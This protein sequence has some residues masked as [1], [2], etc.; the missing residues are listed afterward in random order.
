MSQESSQTLKHTSTWPG[1]FGAYKLSRDAVRVNLW[2]LLGLTV[3]S[4]IIG[5][6]IEPVA[7][8]LHIPVVITQIISYAVSIWLT[9]A[10]TITYLASARHIKLPIEEALRDAVSFIIKYFLLSLLTML[11]VGLSLLLLIIPFFFVA[12][13]LVLA[14]YFLIDKKLGPVE[15]LKASW[16]SSKGNVGKIYGMIGAAILFAVLMLVLVGIYLSFMYAAVFA[17]FY[18]HLTHQKQAPQAK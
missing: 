1:A 7:K 9:I 6:V 8:A 12:P 2:P 5:M 17:V 3:L 11:V 10:L 14:P 13:R 16:H 15:A 18:L 4:I